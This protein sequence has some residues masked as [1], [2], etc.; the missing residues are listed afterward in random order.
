MS[1]RLCIF[2]A[3]IISA[4]G[5]IGS[6]R[7]AENGTTSE[8]KVRSKDQSTAAEAKAAPAGR[9]SIELDRVLT[10]ELFTKLPVGTT[11]A[12]P[13]SDA[14]FLRRAYLDLVGCQPT[15]EE[16]RRFLNDPSAEKRSGLIATLLGDP[17][18]GANAAYYWRDVINARA[19]TA[20]EGPSM[21]L[22]PTEAWLTQQFND[23]VGWDK[24]VRAMIEAK[25]PF[26]DHGEAALLLSQ[27]FS[28]VGLAGETSRIF[29]GIQIQCAECHDHPTD[30]WKRHEFHEF[31]AFFPRVGLAPFERAKGARREAQV[32]S[33]DDAP[34]VRPSNMR[35]AGVPEY[36]MPDPKNPSSPGTP[37]APAFF[38][39]GKKLDV[40]AK[41]IERRGALAEALTARD[42]PWFAKAFV[43]RIWAELVGEGFYEPV[44]D[45]GPDRACSAPRTLDYLAGGF[46]ERGYDVK[47]LYRTIMQSAAYQRESRPRRRAEDIPFTANA[48]QPLRADQLSSVLTQIVGFDVAGSR[49]PPGAQMSTLTPLHKLFGYDPSNR[50]DEIA[51]TIPQALMLMNSE[52]LTRAVNAQPEDAMLAKLLAAAP[53]DARAVTEL[54]LRCLAREPSERERKVCLEHVAA[55][56]ERTAAFEDLLWSLLNSEE[57]RFRN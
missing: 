20:G 17:R 8:S 55:V 42:N 39:S 9:N 44:D 37:I 1:R 6:L 12:P 35:Y 28:P 49:V 41:D 32:A 46:T 5:V 22:G 27:R 14:I 50:R 48:P 47:W 23:S 53:D 56:G 11:L 4:C 45:I 19:T 30:R 51:P 13:T 24:I 16:V 2:S 25:G 7:A 38:L 18:F 15:A 36:F 43:N 29:L 10:E 54:Y 57:L 21:H 31:A 26:R 34:Q 3:A 52:V 33:F 40:G